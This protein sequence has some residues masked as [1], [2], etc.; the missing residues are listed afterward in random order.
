M[1][2]SFSPNS[3]RPNLPLRKPSSSPMGLP[4]IASTP[5]RLPVPPATPVGPAVG[6]IGDGPINSP[7]SRDQSAVFGSK[8]PAL[9][10]YFCNY[11]GQQGNFRCKRCK[12]TPYCSVACQTEDWNAHRHMCKTVDQEPA[13]EKPKETTAS[14]LTADRA[15]LLESKH[16]DASILQRVYLK[17]LHMTKIIKGTDI[18]ASVVEF[19]SPGRFFLL[20]QS[21]ELLEALQSIS[22]ELQ[23][24]YSC[25]SVMT[26]VP[27]VGEVCAVQFSADLNWYRGLVKTLTADQKTAN[28]LY[29]DF[30]NEEDVPVERIKP[31]AANIQLFCPCAMECCISGVMP[32]T[33]DW[34]G[35]CCIA[36]KQMLAGKTVT[37][38]LV[39]TQEN[40]H[41]HAVDILLSMGKQL[42]KFLLEHGYAAEQT[43]NVTRTQQDI[44]AMV[45]AS[46]ENFKRLSDGKDDNTWA[47]PPEPLTQAVGDAFSVVVTHLQSPDDVIVQKVEN[48]RVIQDL[49]LKLREHCIQ[50]A[51]PKN[52]RPAPGTVCCAQFSEDKQWYRAKVL[53]Y[54]SEKRV[55]V[56][57]LD[58]GNSEEV[59]L[60]HLQPISASLLALPM[61]A[62]PCGL[63]GVQPVGESWSED[64]LLALQRRVSNRILHIEIQGAQ[65]GKALV[66]MIDEA[67]DP[68]ANVAELLT[69]A[70]FAAPAPPP[71]SGDHQ[72]EPTAAAAAEPHV[73]SPASETLVW[74]C[75]ELPSDGQTVALLASVVE[76]PS[77][78]YCRINNPTDHQLLI[79]LGAELKQHCETEAS[80]FVPKVGEPCCAMFPGDGEWYR[81][82]VNELSEEVSVNFVDYGYSMKVDKNHLRS[83]TPQLLTLPYQA[84]RCWLTGVEPLGSEWSSEALLWFQTRVDGEQLS[85]RVL[86]V[87]EQGYGVELE[88]RGQNVADAL[89]SEE[90]AKAPGTISKEMHATAGSGDQKKLPEKEYR[91][92]HEQASNQTGARS[93]DIPTEGRTST[94]SE[95]PSFPVDW[96]MVELPLNETFQPCI[97]AITGP[98]LFYLLSPNQVD[99]QKLQ[100]VMMEVAAYCSN[101]QASLS[102]TVLSRPAPGA[103][104]CAKFSADDKWYRAVVLEVGE[105]E[106][107]VIYADYGNTEKVP[108][109]RILPIPMYL[110]Q[111][112]FQVSRCALIGKEHFPAEFP[113]EVLQMFQS[114]LLSGVTATVKSYDGCVHMLSLT[115]LTEN[116]GGDVTTMIIDA[117][118]AQAK[119]NPCP[120]TTQKAE[121]KVSSTSTASAT[122]PDSTQPLS[123]QETQKGLQNT[124]TTSSQTITPELTPQS[125]QQKKTTP[126]ASVNE[127]PV[128]KI[129]KQM[130]PPCEI[131]KTKD[132]QTSGCCCLNLKTKI[133]HLEQLMQLQLSLIKQIVGQT[134]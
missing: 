52:F 90:L 76:N 110:L 26:Y 122:V 24:T 48:A 45:S 97:V 9:T 92:I 6:P 8:P 42:S 16:D 116:G 131:T 57:Y 70:G 66:A 99:Q 54:S 29:I 33:G 67:S 39:E 3:V 88:S 50:A 72:V 113:E 93:K 58:F 23:K 71:T 12:K 10:V 2:R 28:I 30:G 127:D 130:E 19:Y 65:D 61:Q 51:A 109:S 84:V 85:A 98:S 112:P 63:A 125:P 102:S 21:P 74:S 32:V 31:L 79:K 104:C 46:L 35:E 132:A 82:M 80:P 22:A 7:V 34:S 20:A 5:P 56:G 83:I 108:F 4:P 133:D 121:Q 69:S 55:C 25:P 40:G 106:M 1:Y 13:K 64:C 95:A 41:I 47:N 119:S 129:I 117:I 18:Q 38:R 105:N 100:E 43:V 118:Q 128:E 17:D 126:T 115:W 103:A 91:Q 53:A 120:S 62:I 37:V 73:P 114:L 27:H 124:T 101:I 15:G 78:F 81:A 75:I 89:I 94:T 59:D 44:N 11:C 86:S 60:G 96:K 68:Q 14:P 87:T 107:S 36:L 77:E 111:L 49:Q 123:K 134:K